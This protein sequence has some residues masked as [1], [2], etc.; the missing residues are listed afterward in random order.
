VYPNDFK[1][2]SHTLQATENQS[3]DNRQ[4]SAGVMAC[5]GVDLHQKV[6]G[7]NRKIIGSK[8]LVFKTFKNVKSA[9]FWVLIF[10]YICPAIYS[11]NQV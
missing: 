10:F 6:G 5:M 1:A 3:H 9:N 2:V 8:N 7:P 11:T 4:G